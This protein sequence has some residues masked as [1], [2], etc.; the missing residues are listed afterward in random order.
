MPAAQPKH[1]SKVPFEFCSRLNLTLLTGLKARDLAELAESLRKV[2]GSVIYHHTHHFLAQHQHLSPEP[3]N[4]FAYWITN[5]LLEDRLGEE[6]AA[7]DVLRFSTIRE[8]RSTLVGVIQ[9]YLE[10][11]GD[12]RAAPPGLEFHFMRSVSFVLPTGPKVHTLREFR[13][14]L[15]QVSFN[16]ISYHMFDARLRLEQG[17]NDFSKW[18]ESSLGES[19][20]AQAIRVVDPYTHT[21]EGLRRRIVRLID[22]RLES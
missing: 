22:Q 19:Q 16:A 10:R 3:P 13:D 7:I 8:L 11:T 12:V 1:E 20:L 5:I 6:M 21:E 17:D 4:D 18:I 15:S 9:N 2:P 14:A